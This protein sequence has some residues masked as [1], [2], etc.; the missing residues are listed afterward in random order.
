MER[1]WR[2]A[3]ADRTKESLALDWV[4][5]CIGW[6]ERLN[7]ARKLVDGKNHLDSSLHFEQSGHRS[8]AIS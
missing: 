3:R 2:E 4:R 7:A 8:H 5:A 1:R 6:G